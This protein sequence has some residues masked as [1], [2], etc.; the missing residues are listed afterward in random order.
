[1]SVQF[2]TT[3][4]PSGF[5]TKIDIDESAVMVDGNFNADILEALFVEAASILERCVASISVELSQYAFESPKRLP[6][7]T[8]HKRFMQAHD[9]TQGRLDSHRRAK[10]GITEHSYAFSPGTTVDFWI[11]SGDLSFFEKVAG[12]AG[13]TKSS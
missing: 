10:R 5:M 1:M 9:E 7:Q 12:E 13:W 8:A 3:P 4:S 11:E 2:K 6:L